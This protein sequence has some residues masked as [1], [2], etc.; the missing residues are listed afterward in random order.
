M[1]NISSGIYMI[2]NNDNLIGRFVIEDF[3]L[4]PKRIVVNPPNNPPNPWVVQNNGDGTYNLKAGGASCAVID[5]K[6][7]A[8]LIDEM[9]PPDAKKWTI[10]PAGENT[11]VVQKPSEDAVWDTCNAEPGMESQLKVVPQNGSPTQRFT[12]IPMRE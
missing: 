8:V 2:K 7:V 3:S 12:F 5:Q 4:N 6:L 10:T 9:A 11:F 1:S